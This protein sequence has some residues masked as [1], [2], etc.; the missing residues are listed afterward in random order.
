MAGHRWPNPLL[1]SL[2]R[3]L[4][5]LFDGLERRRREPERPMPHLFLP[6]YHSLAYESR[7]PDDLLALASAYAVQ[8]EERSGEGGA[9]VVELGLLGLP[10]ELQ[11]HLGGAGRRGGAGA[12][13]RGG[14]G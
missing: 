3:R 4:V 2:G 11:R 9:R 10:A 12:R 5:T 13:G 8:A 6:P 14:G 1:A 7:T